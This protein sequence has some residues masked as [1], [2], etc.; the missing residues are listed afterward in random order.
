VT[1]VPDAEL[2]EELM[3]RLNNADCSAT[4]GEA[5]IRPTEM[6]IQVMIKARGAILS[7]EFEADDDHL[8]LAQAMLKIAPQVVDDMIAKISEAAEEAE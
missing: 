8:R 4:I 2:L 7:V 1:Q 6:G 5:S 3:T